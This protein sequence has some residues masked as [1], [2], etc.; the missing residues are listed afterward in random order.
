MR[1]SA[2]RRVRRCIL[3]HARWRAALALLPVAR[4]SPVAGCPNHYRHPGGLLLAV[5]YAIL[6]YLS[7]IVVALTLGG[8]LLAPR[9]GPQPYAGAAL[10]LL[11]SASSGHRRPDP[12]RHLLLVPGH[13]GTRADI[14]RARVAVQPG[15][16]E[17]APGT[18]EIMVDA[19]IRLVKAGLNL[20]TNDWKR[21]TWPAATSSM[22]Y[23]R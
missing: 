9:S 18:A 6:L 15:G 16:D 22:S 3:E 19:R 5:M 10:T 12:G 7:K 8:V 13:V 23:K 1:G 21:I 14:R 2:V 20:S 17:T 4:C 11:P